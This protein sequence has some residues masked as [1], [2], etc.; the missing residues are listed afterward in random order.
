[1]RKILPFILTILATVTAFTQDVDQSAYER[2]I[3]VALYNQMVPGY[4]LQGN[5]KIEADIKYLPPVELQDPAIPFTI[6][7]GK[8]DEVLPKSKVRAISFDGHIYLPEDLGDS[9]VWVM[10]EREG[11]I[12]ETIYFSPEPAIN[13]KYYKVNH[14]VTN[15]NTHEGHFVGSLAINFNKIMSGMTSENAEISAKISNREKGYRF[16]DYKKIAAEFNLWF[17]DKYPKRI[18]YIGE[19][20]DFQA[21]IDNDI[22]NYLPKNN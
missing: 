11:A 8:G 10:L 2:Y 20:P 12:R 15:I 5:K 6:N 17:Q 7:T 9:V 3:N 13:P 4:Y 16:I 14:L 19:I 18:K 1:M 21:L 22:S